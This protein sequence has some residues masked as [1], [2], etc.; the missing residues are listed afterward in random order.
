MPG[1]Q[2][3]R[4][5]LPV[6]LVFVIGLCAFLFSAISPLDDDI[7]QEAFGSHR[8]SF[9]LHISKNTAR[10]PIPGARQIALA[11]AFLVAAASR[12]RDLEDLLEITPSVAPQSLVH[13]HADRSPPL[14]F[15]SIL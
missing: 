10:S 14:P 1:S 8:S 4:R 2:M 11:C 5:H 6:E 9:S 7:Q 12:L 15:S 3:R 13:P